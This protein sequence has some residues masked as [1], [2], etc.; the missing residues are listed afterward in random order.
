MNEIGTF[1]ITIDG[2]S[3]KATTIMNFELYNNYYC[4]YGVKDQNMNYN[5]YSGQIIG[6]TVVPIKNER[7]K[8]LINKIALTLTNAIKGEI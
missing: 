6:N 3:H 5:I 1:T 4:I 8:N 7:D 2:Q